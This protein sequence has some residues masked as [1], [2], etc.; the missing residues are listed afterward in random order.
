MT[1]SRAVRRA[2]VMIAVCVL[3]CIG[4]GV[5]KEVAALRQQLKEATDQIERTQKA[6]ND[7]VEG[8]Y[9][10]AARAV[11]EAKSDAEKVKEQAEETVA[12]AKAEVEEQLKALEEQKRKLEEELK[13]RGEILGSLMEDDRPR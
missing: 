3:C 2:G 4:C 7:R 1:R 13:S 5:S 6:L 11:A 12:K 9:A 10:E 8:I